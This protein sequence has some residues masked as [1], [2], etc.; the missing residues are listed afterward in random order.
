[1][2]WEDIQRHLDGLPVLAHRGSRWYRARKFLSRHRVEA[3]AAGLV[4]I[5]LVG[6][7]TVALRQAAAARRE[8]DRA[9]QALAQSNE[10]TD[11][12]V[13]L[14]RTPAPAGATREQVTAKDMLATGT[15]RVEQ[16]AARP[17]V[18]AQMLDALG[19]VNDQI[20][21]FAD[22]EQM[23]RRALALRKEHLGENSLDVA[24]TLNNLADVLAQTNRTDEATRLSQEALT[25]QRRVLGPIHPDVAVTLAALARRTKDLAA[26]ESLLVA[27]RDIQRAALGPTDPAVA[28]ADFELGMI[29]QTRGKYKEAETLYREGIAIRE[30]IG[31]DR[32][33]VALG[34]VRLAQLIELHSDQAAEAESLYQNA[35]GILQAENPPRPAR[36]GGAL[37]GLE[38]LAHVRGDH[39]RAESYARQLLDVH[40]RTI[41]SEH[42]IT[43]EAMEGV[44]EHLAAQKRYAEA[45]SVLSNALAVVE[46]SVGS[47][48]PRPAW[49]LTTRGRIR[50]A[51]GRWT[52]AESDL[53][54]AMAVLQQS[55]ETPTEFDGATTALLAQVV[56]H[57]GNMPESTDLYDRAAKILRS[58]PPRSVYGVIAAYATLADH[59]KKIG[60]PE[61]EAY[62]R[63][64]VR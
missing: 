23:L 21:R 56:E 33:T 29:L 15:A 25:I 2:L 18:Q 36:W 26:S 44:G 13:R 14:F 54:R 41:G 9:E 46:R 40:V 43:T 32:G 10:V 8:R 48:H 55:N 30:Q 28:T 61:D 19:R 37:V 62:F 39:A 11:F 12:L 35:L 63:G 6:G 34:K 27:A 38:H 1:V 42:P 5:S 57:G 59:Y 31:S 64:L 24:I 7:A 45:D 22:A 58:N 60:K 20:G 49:L 51:A 3:V 53:R 4:A 50:A 47:I 52:E 16:L 17:V